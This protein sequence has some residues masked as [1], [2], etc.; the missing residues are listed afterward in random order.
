MGEVGSGDI[1]FDGSYYV[2]PRISDPG[3]GG[4]SLT[5]RGGNWCPLYI[6]QEYSEVNR[7]IP[8]KFSDWMI[9]LRLFP[10][11]RASTSRWTS[12]PRYVV[13]QPIASQETVLLGHASLD[14]GKGGKNEGWASTPHDAESKRKASHGNGSCISRT[15]TTA[16]SAGKARTE[17]SEIDRCL[18]TTAIPVYEEIERLGSWLRRRDR[19]FIKLYNGDSLVGKKYECLSLLIYSTELPLSHNGEN[20]VVAVDDDGLFTERITHF[21]VV[22]SEHQICMARRI[23]KDHMEL[24]VSFFC[25]VRRLKFVCVCPVRFVQVELLK[26]QLLENNKQ[27]HWIPDYVKV[28]EERSM[29]YIYYKYS[30]FRE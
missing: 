10:N 11:R 8:I 6:E 26:E 13:S 17:I 15:Q 21:S 24:V 30:S 7:G 18:K 20:L 14:G 9:K 16:S 1:I 29:I 23:S 28:T 19:T 2:L 27:T 5:Y 3:G 4:L 25:V 22:S 12:Q